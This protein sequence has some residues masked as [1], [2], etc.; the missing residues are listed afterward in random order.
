MVSRLFV[1][2]IIASIAGGALQ[3]TFFGFTAVELS[4]KI[5]K[6][7]FRAILR[8]DSASDFTCHTSSCINGI[9]WQLHILMMTNIA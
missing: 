1:I 9:A 3:N 6:L 4:A 7:S 8:Q 5:Q 2:A